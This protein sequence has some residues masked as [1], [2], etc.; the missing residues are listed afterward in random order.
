MPHFT[1]HVTKNFQLYGVTRLYLRPFVDWQCTELFYV[2]CCHF[3]LAILFCMSQVIKN[4][5]K[6]L[7]QTTRIVRLFPYGNANFSFHLL[8]TKE[9]TARKYKKKSCLPSSSV[10][11]RHNWNYKVLRHTQT[12]LKRSCMRSINF[13]FISPKLDFVASLGSLKF[14]PI[15]LLA[16]C[17]TIM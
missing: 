1:P 5:N 13:L 2:F 14:Q 8:Y 15:L 4:E 6:E 7:F 12:C 11:W 16:R 9:W 17:I 3:F 10:S